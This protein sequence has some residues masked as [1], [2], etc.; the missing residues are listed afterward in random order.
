V[1]VVKAG[2]FSV[3]RIILSGFG[4]ETM[5]NLNLGIPTAYLAAFTIVV[6]SIIALTKDDLKAR[7]AYSTV[8]QLSYVIIGVTMLTPDAVTGGLAHIAHHV[9]FQDNLF[10]AAGA[11]Y[12]ATTT[13]RSASWAGSG[14][15]CPSPSPCSPWPPCP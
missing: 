11:I 1:A 2:V 13:R 6:A 14:A 4:L 3:S 12:V 10:F 9:L 8:S 5:N 15:R 7:L